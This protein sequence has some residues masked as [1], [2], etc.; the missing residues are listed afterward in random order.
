MILHQQHH[1]VRKRLVD[2]EPLHYLRSDLRALRRMPEEMAPARIIRR[3]SERLSYIVEKRRSL[4][5]LTVSRSRLHCLHRVDAVLKHIVFVVSVALIESFHRVKLGEY[6]SQ[7]VY[8][9]SHHIR[10][11]LS[12]HQFPELRKD[13]FHRQFFKQTAVPE[14]RRL[15]FFLDPE[16]QHRRKPHRAHYP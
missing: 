7:H 16:S 10:R 2:P 13:P 12:C 8:V 3:I 4:H 6:F 14:H 1:P 5:V 15:S 11:M 9:S